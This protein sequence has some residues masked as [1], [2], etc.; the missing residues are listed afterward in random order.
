MKYCEKCY[1][2]FND[3]VCPNCH[4]NHIRE[5]ADND[6]CHLTTQTFMYAEMLKE[7]LEKENISFETTAKMGAGIAL[8]V[9]PMLEEYTFYV[10]YY[11]YHRAKDIVE[12]MFHKE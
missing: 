5:V 6:L 10:P 3:C 2:V 8:K 9:A 12:N 4:N 11:D 1:F 7:V